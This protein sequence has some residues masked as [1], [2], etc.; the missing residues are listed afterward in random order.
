MAS[1]K[2]DRVVQFL[3]STLIDDGFSSVETFVIHGTP[4]FAAKKDISDGERWRA[5]AVSATVSARFIVRYSAFTAALTA[6]DQMECEG[7]TYDINGIKEGEGRRRWL[8]ITAA[9]K[10]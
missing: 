3:R 9:A 5:G 7:V 4:V 2:L 1:G 10:P 8:E 6:A